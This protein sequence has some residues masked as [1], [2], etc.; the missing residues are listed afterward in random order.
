MDLSKTCSTVG[1]LR[2]FF[3]LSSSNL[4]NNFPNYIHNIFIPRITTQ[5]HI[6][7][8]LHSQNQPNM[9]WQIQA[10]QL[11]SFWIC[12]PTAYTA[13]ASGSSIC[14]FPSCSS[15]SG[16]WGKKNKALDWVDQTSSRVNLKRL[17][18]KSLQRNICS[19][20]MNAT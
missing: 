12:T 6:N 15:S 4:Y 14:P 20:E 9:F 16:F 7:K 8:P 5:K 17:S 1:L 13:P 19:I 11:Q 3:F 2:V 10:N 18:Y